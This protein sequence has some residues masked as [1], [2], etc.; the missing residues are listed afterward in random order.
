M[1]PTHFAYRIDLW[2]DDEKQ[3]VE[4]LADVGALTVVMTIFAQRHSGGSQSF[5]RISSRRFSMSSGSSSSKRVSS[6]RAS[7]ITWSISSS[8]AWIACVSRCSAR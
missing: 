2:S 5:L 4:H 3:V 1:T 6:L 8:L 7:P